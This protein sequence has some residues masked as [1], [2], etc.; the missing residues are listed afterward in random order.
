MGLDMNKVVITKPVMGI[1]HM[2]VCAEKDS[3]DEDILEVCN[4]EN[5]S[6]TSGG[7]SFVIRKDEKYPQCDPV[8][9]VDDR[10]RLHF[11]VGC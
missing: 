7:W 5:P 8:Q 10:D 6:G 1:C 11:M 9:C 3:T 2:Q 4:S